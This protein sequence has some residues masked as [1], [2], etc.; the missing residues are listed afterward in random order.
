MTTQS[1]FSID[2]EALMGRLTAGAV[3]VLD[4]NPR[5]C[6]VMR[7]LARDLL[8]NVLADGTCCLTED[9]QRETGAKRCAR[10]A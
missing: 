5:E 10:V 6:A 1:P 4:L 2:R 8:V 3:S 9:G 7:S